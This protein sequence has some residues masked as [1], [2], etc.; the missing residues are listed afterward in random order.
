MKHYEARLQADLNLIQQR[1]GNLAEGVRGAVNE[2]IQS[3]IA[4]DVA[5]MY[6]VILGDGIFNR[7]TRSIDSACRAF[8]ARHVP[9]AGHL[10]F[11][12]SVL[13]MTIS[14][15]RIGDYAVTICRVGVHLDEPLSQDVVNNLMSLSDQAGQMVEVATRAFLEQDPELARQT[16]KMALAIDVLHDRILVDILH[17]TTDQSISDVAKLLTVFDKLERVSDQAKNICEEVVFITTGESKAP[18]H[19]RVLFLDEDGSFMAP[20]AVALA[21][22]AFPECGTYFC[23]SVNPAATFHPQLEV[24]SDLVSLNLPYDQPVGLQPLASSPAKYHVI[25]A[26][27]MDDSALPVIPFHSIL[28]KWTIV[29]RRDVAGS[30]EVVNDL[31]ERLRSLMEILSGP[32]AS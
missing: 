10:R 3:L 8:V 7:E 26:V 16:K 6:E 25:V 17:G 19:Y 14:I 5:R 21:K 23:E 11:V 22:R 31:S 2:A 27:N 30:R 32:D 12:S 15:E 18:K 24:L 20:L 1:V 9:A 28:Q 29:D 4:Q 13:R